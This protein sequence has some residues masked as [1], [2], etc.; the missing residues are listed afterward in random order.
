MKKKNSILTVM[1][2]WIVLSVFSTFVLSTIAFYIFSTEVSK[3][4]SEQLLANNVEDLRNEAIEADSI[5]F[6]SSARTSAYNME[7]SV[8]DVCRTEEELIRVFI[9]TA[10]QS[11]LTELMYVDS[12]GTVRAA[13]VREFVGFD[14]RSTE[15]SRQFLRLLEDDPTSVADS[16]IVTPLMPKGLMKDEP[17]KY[18]AARLLHR[19]GFV[20][21][22]LSEERVIDNMD[23]MLSNSAHYR[24]VGERGTMYIFDDGLRIVSA[25]IACEA[26]SMDEVGIDESG[27][28]TMP[29]QALF[30]ATLDGERCLCYHSYLMGYH[31]LAVQPK[32]ESTYNRDAALKSRTL[33]GALVFLLLFVALWLF[34]RHLVSNINRINRSLAKITDGNLNVRVAACDTVEMQQLADHANHMVDRLKG[35]IHEAENRNAADL[36]LAKSIQSS[37]LP[38]VFPAFPEHQEFDIHALMKTAREVGG[39]FYDF[40]FVGENK[41]ALVMAD[42]SGKGIPA[43][44][45]M[46]RSKSALKN[47]ASTGLPLAQVCYEV[48]NMLCKDNDTQ[49]F[50]TCW[51]GVMDLQTGELAYI[52]AGHNKP[53]VRRSGGE[54][55]FLDCE[56]NMP[57]AVFEDFPYKVQTLQLSAGDE[58]FF[59]TDGVTEAMSVGLEQFGDERLLEVFNT[60]PKQVASTSRSI[61]M[62]VLQE[63][64]AF[65]MGAEQS[66]D[67]TMMSFKYLG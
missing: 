27:L 26:K 36:A 54:F 39:D 30:E 46:M 65:A 13:N 61:C 23:F 45:F 53:L 60:M 32:S 64:Q 29:E 38:S 35:F 15:L 37:T 4:K 59:Y 14:M 56:P 5:V 67:I 3:V 10:E 18:M 12:T 51:I 2:K 50:F 7:A 40:F 20:A 33:S 11:K 55:T 28:K 66:D 58:L 31:M 34:V 43:A 6:M 44:M 57:M 17:C 24:R 25:P 1:T 62:N 9:F 22:A 41:L 47:H 16:A 52:N 8:L 49:T 42:V 48:N 19:K 21:L 63:V